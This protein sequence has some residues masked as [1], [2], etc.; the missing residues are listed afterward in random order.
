[1]LQS[2]VGGKDGV[3]G[4][5][6]RGGNLRGRVNRELQFGLLSIVD[7]QTFHEKGGEAGSSTTTEGVEEQEALKAGA[8]VSDLA[9]AVQDRVDE[10]L[11][12]GVVASGV[13]VGGIFLASDHLLRV[14]ELLVGAGANLI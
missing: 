7:G 5:N 1:M 13:V 12:D 6:N 8:L 14:E 11:A 9:D 10:L 4:F 2:G 3:V